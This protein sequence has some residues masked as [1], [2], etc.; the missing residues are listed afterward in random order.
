[1]KTT[2][3]KSTWE[4]SASPLAA[5]L[6]R[7]AADG[8]TVVENC[9]QAIG[10]DPEAFRDDLAARGLRYIA[11]VHTEGASPAEHLASLESRLDLAARQGAVW[12]N[13][14]TGKDHFDF[15]DNCRLFAA[16]QA[17]A[18][19][20][21]LP[22]THETHRGRALFSLPATRSFLQALP[23]MRLCADF[24]HWVCVHE[25]NL[26]DQAAALDLAISRSDYIH[27]RVGHSQ[28]PQVSHPLAPENRTWLELHQGWW[29]RIL[30]R[31]QAE[32][33]SET[34]VTP[35][36]GPAPYLPVT[37]FDQR[38]VADAWSVNVALRDHLAQ[39]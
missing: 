17:W 37:P 2:Y 14:H 22:L 21:G 25:S 35:E 31:R 32:G 6:D 38:P 8:F 27:A 20:H 10:L 23:E 39:A 4:M 28:G 18:E 34:F 7:L 5:I 33:Q 19:H 15:A 26:A 24:S 1:M 13:C 3:A 11:Q 36:A 12:L 29:Q 30:N 16:S 9:P